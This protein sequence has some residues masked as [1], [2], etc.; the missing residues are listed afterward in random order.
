MED[1]FT[2]LI[3]VSPIAA[4]LIIVTVLFLRYMTKRDASWEKTWRAMSDNHIKS[5]ESCAETIKENTVTMSKVEK[6]LELRIKQVGG[7]HG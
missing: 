1:L 5:H 6:L 2:K 3:A 7:D 4:A